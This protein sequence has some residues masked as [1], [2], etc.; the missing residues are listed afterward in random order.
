MRDAKQD[1]LKATKL[2]AALD[3]KELE[4]VAEI[5]TELNVPSGTVLARE[6]HQGHD[7]F[8]IV[9]G[10]GRL[11]IDYIG[12]LVDS[13]GVCAAKRIDA[14]A[15]NAVGVG[16]FFMF[17]FSRFKKVISPPW[18]VVPQ[19]SIWRIA[20]EQ[21]DVLVVDVVYKKVGACTAI[22]WI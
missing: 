12:I 8:V 1:R 18:V 2:F 3:R 22:R 5:T 17:C 14:D 4:L 15:T 13:L 19:W 20:S 7:A 6:G 21:H 9:A 10:N 11:H 16:I